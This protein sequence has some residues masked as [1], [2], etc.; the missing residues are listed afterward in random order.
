MEHTQQTMQL[1][2]LWILKKKV[3]IQNL[4]K[5][6]LEYQDLVSDYYAPQTFIDKEGRRVQ[7]GWI[8]IN[9]PFENH[10]WLGMMSLPRVIE[11]KNKEITTNV[12]PNISLFI[13][14]GNK[15]GYY[16]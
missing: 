2:V 8:R 15:Y 16:R 4:I 11:V 3:V 7:F 12:H 5:M 14:K 13:Y 10:T 1:W 9:K 6:I